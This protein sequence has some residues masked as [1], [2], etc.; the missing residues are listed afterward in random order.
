MRILSIITFTFL[1]TWVVK[2]YNFN[3]RSVT[4]YVSQSLEQGADGLQ[5]DHPGKLIKYLEDQGKR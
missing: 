3:N 2:A 4:P 1:F 5:T